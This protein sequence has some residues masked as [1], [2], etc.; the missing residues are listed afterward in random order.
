MTT[1]LER[2]AEAKKRAI[3]DFYDGTS[4][5]SAHWFVCILCGWVWRDGERES[6]DHDCPLEE[7]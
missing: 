1:D 5:T 2:L 6:H 3:K 7:A 4:P